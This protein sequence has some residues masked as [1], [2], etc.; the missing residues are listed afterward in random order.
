LRAG[1]EAQATTFIHGVADTVFG[2]GM[3]T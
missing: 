2:A 1:F 3:P